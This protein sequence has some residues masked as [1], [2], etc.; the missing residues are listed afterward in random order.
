MGYAPSSMSAGPPPC[1]RFAQRA[2]TSSL[3]LQATRND[4]EGLNERA[5][6]FYGYCAWDPSGKLVQGPVSF[7]PTTLGTITQIAPTSSTEFISG[8]TWAV[9]NGMVVNMAWVKVIL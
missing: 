9:G 4:I 8:A 3:V 5:L 2:S 7:N 6:P 1:D